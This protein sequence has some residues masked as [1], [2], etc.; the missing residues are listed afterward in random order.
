MTCG[1]WVIAQGGRRSS[2][3][4]WR[5]THGARRM[6]RDASPKSLYQSLSWR[7]SLSKLAFRRERVIARNDVKTFTYN[8]EV[9]HASL[10]K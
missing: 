10:K 4:A 2:H 8:P 9:T 5:G 7:V 3:G 6:L 1:A